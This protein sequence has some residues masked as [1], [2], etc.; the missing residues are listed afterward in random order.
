MRERTNVLATWLHL[1]LLVSGGL[2][3]H[4]QQEARVFPGD[5]TAEA[6]ERS[7]K[8]MPVAT[9][10]WSASVWIL[11]TSLLVSFPKAGGSRWWCGRKEYRTTWPWKV[12][13]RAGTETN[14]LEHKIQLRKHRP[15][16][17]FQLLG[18]GSHTARVQTVLPLPRSAVYSMA[19][20]NFTSFIFLLLALLILLIVSL[21][22]LCSFSSLL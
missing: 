22:L 12:I 20:H 1:Q 19:L 8:G 4:R 18:P 3:F 6:R 15:P 13:T 9:V 14:A 10:R 7:V 11:T 16:S 2:A 21:L 17:Y 5:M